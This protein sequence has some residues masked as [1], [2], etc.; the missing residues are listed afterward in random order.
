MKKLITLPL[1]VLFCCISI[2]VNA[3]SITL[4]SGSSAPTYSSAYIDQ[5]NDIHLSAGGNYYI[6]QV[7]LFSDVPTPHYWYETAGGG[8]YSTASQG[9][10]RIIVWYREYNTSTLMVAVYDITY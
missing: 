1:L 4:S 3:A 6:D 2:A 7:I 9:A 5:N 10:H 8:A